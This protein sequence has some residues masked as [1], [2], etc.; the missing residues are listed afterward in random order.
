MDQHSSSKSGSAG[1]PAAGSAR[2]GG[3]AGS[4]RCCGCSCAGVRGR[5]VRGRGGAGGGRS[6]GCGSCLDGEAEHLRKRRG[7]PPETHV[8]PRGPQPG[9]PFTAGI[10]PLL[11]DMLVCRLDGGNARGLHGLRNISSALHLVHTRPPKPHNLHMQRSLLPLQSFLSA[12]HTAA[13]I[14]NR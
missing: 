12:Q 4:G 8:Q 10:R 1:G 2:S 14:S 5:G 13:P 3:Y 6:G 7:P 11:A 9:A